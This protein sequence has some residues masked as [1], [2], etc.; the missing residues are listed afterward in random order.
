MADVGKLPWKGTAEL[1]KGSGLGSAGAHSSSGP[2]CVG[3]FQLSLH[4]TD[5]AVKHF[6]FPPV[7]H[8]QDSSAAVGGNDTLSLVWTLG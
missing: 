4:D 1:S 3:G 7:F 8:G 6:C 2:A 5:M